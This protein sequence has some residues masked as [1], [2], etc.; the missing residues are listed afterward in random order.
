MHADDSIPVVLVFAGNDPTGGAGIAADIEALSSQGCHAA[1]VV[2]AVTVQTSQRVLDFQPVAAELI[3]RQGAAI[4]EDLNVAAVKIGMLGSVDAASAVA[5]LLA[6][7]PEAPVVFDPV[8]A[9]GGGG[10]LGGEALIDSIRNSLLPQVS[11]LTPNS[12]EARILSGADNLD[13]A[14]A[15]LIKLG[16]AQV[17]ITGAHEAS[18][19]VQ[20]RLYGAEGLIESWNWPRLPHSYHGSGCTLAASLAGLLAQGFDPARAAFRAQEYTW[21]TLQEGY[22][23]SSGQRFPNRLFWAHTSDH[24]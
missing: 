8:L 9:G 15:A 13:D 16:C 4:I 14:A 22:P 17:L 24:A 6:E 10:D 1:P 11:V 7:L 18:A 5:S 12:P 2:T 19:D 3:Q 21:T 23:L 20:N